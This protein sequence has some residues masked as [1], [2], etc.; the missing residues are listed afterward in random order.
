MSLAVNVTRLLGVKNIVYL[1]SR[2]KVRLLI[3][4]EWDKNQEVDFGF[5][6]VRIL[7]DT[8]ALGGVGGWRG[9]VLHKAWA[10][11]DVNNL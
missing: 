6:M 1:G 3:T 4:I 11:S 9:S 10:L 2:Y 7:L 8:A 5:W